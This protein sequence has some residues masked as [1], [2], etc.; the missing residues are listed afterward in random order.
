MLTLLKISTHVVYNEKCG[1]FSYF[2]LK[3]ST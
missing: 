2:E 3:Y 1:Y